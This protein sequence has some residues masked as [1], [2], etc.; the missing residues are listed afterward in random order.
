MKKGLFNGNIKKE[1]VSY[2]GLSMVVEAVIFF[3]CGGFFVGISFSN[4]VADQA[5]AWFCLALGVI[6]ILVGVFDISGSIF[7]IRTY[8]KY[9]KYVKWFFN[10]AHYFVGCESKEYVGPKRGR[11]GRRGQRAFAAVTGIAELE[12]L[13]E[14]IVYPKKMKW[15]T[16]FATV[17]IFLSFL[18][19]GLAYVA[20]ERVELLP[21]NLQNEDLILGA[22]AVLVVA[23]MAVSLFFAL[24]VRKIREQTK[25]EFIK[26]NPNLK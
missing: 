11:A 8:P 19:I 26:N 15:Y 6:S 25:A 2:I 1:Y 12:K 10:S 22:M 13:Y 5:T 18:Y 24:R 21:P 9:Q 23:T 17:G 7:V 16:A 4:H 14:G 3:G 20:I